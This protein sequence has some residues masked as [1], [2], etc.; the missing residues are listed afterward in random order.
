[1]MLVLIPLDQVAENI[2]IILFGGVQM[3]PV[4]KGIYHSGCLVQLRL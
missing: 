3:I 1:M 2:Q 4:E